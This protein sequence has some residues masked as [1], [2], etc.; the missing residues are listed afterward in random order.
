MTNKER[1]KQTIDK[2]FDKKNNYNKIQNRL[3]NIN[4]RYIRYSL[5]TACLIVVGVI[6]I[7]N[8][9]N[10]GMQ[11]EINIEPINKIKINTYNK[12]SSYDFDGLNENTNNND[13]KNYVMI[14]YFEVLNNLNI[15]NDF[16][17]KY[18]GKTRV[19]VLDKEDK[20]YGKINNYEFWFKNTNNNRKIIICISDKNEP[21]SSINIDINNS[22]KSTINN[23]QLIIY[24]YDNKFISKFD[25]KDYKFVIET[26]DITENEFINLLKSI[27]K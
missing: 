1:F 24:K 25:Y 20:D 16:N 17:I 2:D 6:F 3:N 11:K 8:R 13:D 26:T 23:V 7:L 19:R 21:I 14:P 27:I 15:P 12:T 9:N 22:S 4:N 18:D 5:T 10:I